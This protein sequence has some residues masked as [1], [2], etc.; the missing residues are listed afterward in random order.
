MIADT[1][2]QAIRDLPIDQVVGRYIKL[3]K[4]A[5]CCPFHDEKTPSFRVTPQK[6]FFKCFGCG[7]SGDG[8][9]FV[10]RMDSLS[11]YEAIEKLAQDHHIDLIYDSS[12]SE[13]ER[14][15]RKDKEVLAQE[16][17]LF[18]Q[19]YFQENLRKNPDALAYL[20]NRGF[21]SE[22]IEEW[23][24]G[25]APD[26][27]KGLTKR[28]IEREWY[29]I[30]SELG[31]IRTKEGNS[32]DFYRNRITIPIHNKLGMLVGFGARLIAPGEPKYINPTESFLYNKS[33]VLF[34]LQK[35]SKAIREK[36]NAYLVEGY[37][38]VISMHMAGAEN[39]VAS[40]GTA[41]DEKH[42]Q[43]IK[44]HTDSLTL[45]QDGDKA[46]MKA[47]T[48]LVPRCLKIGLNTMVAALDN[49]DPDDYA[50]QYLKNETGRSKENA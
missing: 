20:N 43:E 36:K 25:F 11:F 30:A 41:V 47:I 50:Q 35:A 5:A 13:E 10:Q 31:L 3:T 45:M 34:G 6:G 22:I 19:K 33:V 21:N 14:K 40:C 39:T 1:S 32:Y 28:L 2:I 42:L 29:P 12:I 27:S 23:E 24:M 49:S 38:D 26:E 8:I 44:K 17:L 37:F 7:E 46:G 16:V 18:A 48:D 9:R 4:N 15:L